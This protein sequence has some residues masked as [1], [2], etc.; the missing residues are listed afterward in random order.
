MCASFYALVQTPLLIHSGF[1]LSLMWAKKLHA[2]LLLAHA[3][4]VC[5]GLSLCCC[6]CLCRCYCC[7]GTG[8]DSLSLLLLSLLG[9]LLLSLIRQELL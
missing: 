7:L 3:L 4:A 6:V 2:V 8:Y 1:P 5:V 9:V